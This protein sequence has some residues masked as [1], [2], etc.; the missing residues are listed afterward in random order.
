MPMLLARWMF[1]G[2]DQERAGDEEYELLVAK[3]LYRIEPGGEVGRN[4]RGERATQERAD[5]DNYDVLGDDLGGNLR[6]LV[7][8]ARKNFDVQRGREPVSEFVAVANQRH[9]EAQAS[10]RSKKSDH[11]P[12][13]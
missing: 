1:L 3:R 11:G 9:A 5:E 13:S 10:Q 7:N 12:L 4:K 8:F 2:A 6:E